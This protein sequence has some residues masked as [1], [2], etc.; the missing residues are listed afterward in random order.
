M[1]ARAVPSAAFAQTAA[2]ETHLE[3]I[4]EEA[5]EAPPIERKGRKGREI[6]GIT[7]TDQILPIGAMIFSLSSPEQILEESVCEVNSL[8]GDVGTV[9]DRR[10]GCSGID[11][12]EVCLTCNQ[13]STPCNG[14]FGHIVLPIPVINP[15]YHRKVLM[16]LR[17]TCFECCRMMLTPEAMELAG[18]MKAQGSDRIEKIS[19]KLAKHDVCKHCQTPH[20]SISFK[21]TDRS[22]IMKN[23]SKKSEEKKAPVVLDTA[24]IRG[25]FSRL[26]MSD[27]LL[28]GLTESCHPKNMILTVLPV[29][30][31]CARPPL[32]SDGRTGDDD[33]TRLYM[34]IV[35]DCRI[36]DPSVDNSEKKTRRTKG[37]KTP[38]D[39][40]VKAA[41]DLVTNIG[42]IFDNRGGV[43]SQH[44]NGRPYLSIRARVEGKGGGMRGASLGK[45]VNF[46][47]RSVADPALNLDFDE[48]LVPESIAKIHSVPENVAAFNLAWL[49]GLVDRE[50]ANRV[51][52]GKTEATPGVTVMVKQPKGA[53][54]VLKH[55]DVLLRD[56][57]TEFKWDG[58]NYLGLA[59]AIRDRKLSNSVIYMDSHEKAEFYQTRITADDR[60]I[61]DN[62]ISQVVLQEKRRIVLKPG[63]IVWRHLRDG[64]IV[65]LNRQP[66]LSLHSF[67]AVRVVVD[68]TG[69]KAFQVSPAL[70]T[71]FN[72]DY[73]GDEVNI[74]VPQTLAAM[75][76]ARELLGA[77][78]HIL[79]TQNGDPV[80]YPVQDSI[81]SAWLATRDDSFCLDQGQFTTIC[82]CCM[83]APRTERGKSVP[84]S[85][86]SHRKFFGSVLK[87]EAIQDVMAQEGKLPKGIPRRRRV[88]SDATL[89]D[90]E[91]M[92]GWLFQS[93]G[94]H[95]LAHPEDH[96][97]YTQ[98]FR[99][100]L[101][102]ALEM[103]DEMY[104]QLNNGVMSSLSK[105]LQYE[106][107]VLMRKYRCFDDWKFRLNGK[108]VISLS[109]PHG[110]NYEHRNNADPDQPVVKIRNGVLYSG[111]LDKSVLTGRNSLIYAIFNQTHPV[112]GPVEG[113]VDEADGESKRIDGERVAG[114]FITHFQAITN[115]FLLYHNLTVG[116]NDYILHEQAHHDRLKEIMNRCYET[117]MGVLETTTEPNVREHLI[118]QALETAK[119][120]G[121]EIAAS[122]LKS[123]MKVRV[124]HPETNPSRNAW[125][126]MEKI[127]GLLACV[128]SGARGSAFNIAQLMTALG[129][130]VSDDGR[131]QETMIGERSLPYYPFG[132]QTIQQALASRCFIT[133]SF[134]SGLPI[135][136]FFSQA[137][138]SRVAALNTS[139]DVQKVGYENRTRCQFGQLTQVVQDQTV[140]AI[141]MSKGVSGDTIVSFVYNGGFDSARSVSARGATIFCDPR[142]I[143]HA[144]NLEMLTRKLAV[145]APPVEEVVEEA[146]EEEAVE[147]GVVEEE[148]PMISGAE[149]F[150]DSDE[151]FVADEE[152]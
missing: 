71:T 61:R 63:M 87:L 128:M 18:Y 116:L 70:C 14:H 109:L 64:D 131:F 113:E 96:P 89:N 38:L 32:I 134:G 21:S 66:T 123:T 92:H 106:L 77:T 33:L 85:R 119:N 25:I 104:D 105:E 112:E 83:P 76:E 62:E 108:A 23:K 142:K 144:L 72:L 94:D 84:M 101:V 7:A 115:N 39:A 75:V 146:A 80:I 143:A 141:G 17:L 55:G 99:V 46:S 145:T 45:R 54:T 3:S 26:P 124:R 147:T 8:K 40:K 28:L 37:T 118:V 6:S 2:Q 107:K 97:D 110:F 79:S 48:I 74:H 57:T 65:L 49:Q 151:E 34:M 88:F 9:Y 103:Y 152:L 138:A 78:K 31:P 44:P 4:A 36:L 30:P 132:P 69:S 27:V 95:L 12:A 51:I 140:R 1:L 98:P 126:C 29:L 93:L 148:V 81:V 68:R 58:Y 149:L 139:N 60:I 135:S 42:N 86:Y 122:A 16:F 53:F 91:R 43:G 5:Q 82:C 150:G 137:R 133:T 41:R 35:R 129:L 52:I 10:M 120:I 24:F 56:P 102:E 111:V 130:N 114:H 136:D 20:P 19:K 15:L 11:P 125:T 59:E 47:A 22:F 73:D 127:N 67:L 100:G 50:E 121:K 117:V 90:A 13:T